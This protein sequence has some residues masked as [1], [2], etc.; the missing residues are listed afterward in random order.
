M[1]HPTKYFSLG[2]T[3]GG[4]NADNVLADAYV[5]GIKDG[6]DWDAGY[7]AVQKD[8]DE[9]PFDWSN[10][11]RGGMQSWKKLNYIPVED[12]DHIGFGTMT[13]SISRTLE[14]SYNDFAIAQMAYG[15]NKTADAAR[16][17]KESRYWR[18]LFRKDQ[19]S[20]LKGADTG[21]IGF[22]QPKYLN[23]TWGYQDPLKCS[24]IDTSGSICSLQNTAGRLSS[25]VSGNTNCMLLS[26]FPGVYLSWCAHTNV[27][28]ASYPTTWPLSS[29]FSVG[30]PTLSGGLITSTSRISPTLATSPPS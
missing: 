8:A 26:I 17:E 25:R 7:A 27:I 21:F 11:G 5:K 3:Q 19:E 10:E 24:N 30:L 16:Y 23:G 15:M 13:R 6:I 2:F 4:S 22:F 20:Y 18:N 28:P 9:E 14:Y 12:F 1:S 29:P